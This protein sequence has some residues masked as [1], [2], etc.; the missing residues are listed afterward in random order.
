MA[1]CL[2]VAC[3]ALSLIWT[4]ERPNLFDA[5]CVY[6]RR[7]NP[8]RCSLADGGTVLFKSLAAVMCL[9]GK[10][11]LESAVAVRRQ[12][13]DD[14]LWSAGLDGEGRCDGNCF[15]S[16]KGVSRHTYHFLMGSGY[17]MIDECT[18]VDDEW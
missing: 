2:R 6:L 16:T 1:V 15:S 3:V 5:V 8:L 10:Y 12:W 17:S 13:I 7:E 14:D 9:V 4:D 11:L 18:M